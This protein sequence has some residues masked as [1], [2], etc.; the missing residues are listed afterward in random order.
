MATNE[1]VSKIVEVMP[2]QP[3]VFE[4]F[5]E[6]LPEIA[7]K[8]PKIAESFDKLLTP[9]RIKIFTQYQQE[10]T[11][12]QQENL[13]YLKG[14]ELAASIV[15]GVV[16][17]HNNQYE[18]S[19]LESQTEQLIKYLDSQIDNNQN[20]FKGIWKDRKNGRKLCERM[21][22][23]WEERG[24]QQKVEEFHKKLMDLIGNPPPCPQIN[25]SI[26]NS[27]AK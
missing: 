20:Y 26:Q 22:Y 25:C 16:K 21:I 18:L 23:F 27:D 12:Y 17:Y 6:V 13:R 8:T 15:Q 7:E 14:F 4:E 5:L 2:D 9:E 19:K 11:Q 3:Q 1:P 24:D 10:N